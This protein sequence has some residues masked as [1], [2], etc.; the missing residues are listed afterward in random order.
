MVNVLRYVRDRDIPS[1]LKILD[2]IEEFMAKLNV[3]FYNRIIDNTPFNNIIQYVTLQEDTS[4][5]P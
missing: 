5:D 2:T 1:G 3:N 4:I